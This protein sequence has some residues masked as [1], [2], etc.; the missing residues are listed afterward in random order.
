MNSVDFADD[1]DTNDGL[2]KRRAFVRESRTFDMMGRLHADIFQDRHM[3]NEVG[4]KIKLV[5]SKDS[6]LIGAASNV[7]I[8]HASLVVRKVKLTP[9]Q[10]GGVRLSRHVT[11]G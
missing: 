6:C 7:K 1:R 11:L 2:V 9:S 4:F 3:L 5:R 8:M 10:L